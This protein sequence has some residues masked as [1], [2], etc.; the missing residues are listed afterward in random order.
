[1]SQLLPCLKDMQATSWSLIVFWN[2]S[3]GPIAR[4]G[5]DVGLDFTDQPAPAPEQPLQPPAAGEDVDYP[6]YDDPQGDM[7]VDDEDMPPP[8]SQQPEPDLDDNPIEL[9]TG[10]D[11]PFQPPGGGAQVPAPEGAHDDS[12]LEMPLDSDDHGGGPH[13]AGPGYGP[14]PDEPP[15]SMEYHDESPPPGGPP[16]APGAVPQFANPDQVLSP[17]MPWPAPP[18][19]MVPV[20]I[21]PRPRFPIPQ[22]LRPPSPRNVS[23]TRAR[24]THPDDKSKA[25]P[26]TVVG[27]PVVLLPGQSAGKKGPASAGDFPVPSEPA[28]SLSDPVTVP[29]L[30]V[31]EGGI[32]YSANPT[33]GT[34][35]GTSCAGNG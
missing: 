33:P 22:S 4:R 20:P 35:P 32:P 34:H 25:K 18:S 14:S 11:P 13:G 19:Q 12:D 2:E 26:R 23:Q 27:P 7:P 15:V 16:G 3:K 29:G 5:P 21:P 9:H 31:T 30:P 8:A 28:S 24:G 10:D 1:M 6:G 17:P